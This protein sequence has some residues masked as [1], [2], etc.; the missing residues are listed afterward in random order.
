LKSAILA[1]NESQGQDVPLSGVYANFKK[2]PE[3]HP[4]PVPLVIQYLCIFTLQ[5]DLKATTTPVQVVVRQHRH[6]VLS[7]KTRIL[8]Q[9]ERR[10]FFSAHF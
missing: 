5:Q 10:H 4:H 6:M 1:G 7:S 8:P 3:Q 9:H 2:Q